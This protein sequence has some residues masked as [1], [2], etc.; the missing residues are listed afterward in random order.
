MKTKETLHQEKKKDQENQENQKYDDNH[1]QLSI[2]KG[3]WRRRPLASPPSSH[4]L[5]NFDNFFLFICITLSKVGLKKLF[6]CLSKKKKE[7]KKAR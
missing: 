4:N 6:A 7:K 2:G 3:F 5:Q 1:R